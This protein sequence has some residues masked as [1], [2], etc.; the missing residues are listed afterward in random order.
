MTDDL[1]PQ[2][3]SFPPS[4]IWLHATPTPPVSTPLTP[5]S[6][7]FGMA[8]GLLPS[9][10]SFLPPLPVEAYLAGL[11]VPAHGI[12]WDFRPPWTL[13]TLG[14]SAWTTIERFAEEGR[15]R[16]EL[17]NWCWRRKVVVESHGEA[18]GPSSEEE[19]YLPR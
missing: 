11:R 16:I 6:F 18:V 5:P 15:V 10:F 3:T 12:A 1:R 19:T 7:T 17:V 8:G 2:G 9:F 13:R 14:A 4:W